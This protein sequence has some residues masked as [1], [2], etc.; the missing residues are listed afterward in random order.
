MPIN[1]DLFRQMEAEAS[2]KSDAHQAGLAKEQVRQCLAEIERL[3]AAL[4]HIASEEAGW[5]RQRAQR[6]LDD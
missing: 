4:K 3:R 1:I 2:G 5:A 6:A